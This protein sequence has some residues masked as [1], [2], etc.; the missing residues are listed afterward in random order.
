MILRGGRRKQVRILWL[1]QGDKAKHLQITMES[2]S[3]TL[4]GPRE[5]GRVSCK[6]PEEIT[7]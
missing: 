2:Q 5:T 4:D 7:S 6:G 1:A 3:G